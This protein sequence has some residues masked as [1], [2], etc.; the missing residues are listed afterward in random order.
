MKGYTVGFIFDPTYTN[1]LLMHKNRPEWQKG[2][3]NGVGGRIESD[4]SSATCV[5]REVL[6]ETNLKTKEKD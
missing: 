5:V 1:V 6:E 4:E 3:I 2:R